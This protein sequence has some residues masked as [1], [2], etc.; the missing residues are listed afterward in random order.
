MGLSFG[1]EKCWETPCI[2]G[3]EYRHYSAEH[4]CEWLEDI[5]KYHDSELIFQM[6][7]EREVIKL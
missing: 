7:I 1:C 3:W 2:C 4:L 6:L 5:L